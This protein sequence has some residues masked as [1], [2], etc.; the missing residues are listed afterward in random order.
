MN[1]RRIENSGGVLIIVLVGILAI[2]KV[3]T[4]GLEEKVSVANYKHVSYSNWYN[5]KSVKQVMKEGERDQLISL[6]SSGLIAED[7]LNVI[8]ARIQITEDLI[9]KYVEEKNEILV[10][11]ANIPKTAWTQDLNGELG[12]IVGL[13]RWEEI[14][15]NTSRVISKIDL[16]ALFL[17]IGIVFGILGLIIDPGLNLQKVF[18][19]LMLITGF[20]G[21]FF[22]LYGYS[23][24]I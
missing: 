19:G 23:L 10:G 2:M 20:I 4:N 9:K 14:S 16:G 6:L 12:K 13:E 22:G 5:A 8:Q 21:I 18:T 1:K 11:S 7:K 15:I 24:L 17:Q 3:I